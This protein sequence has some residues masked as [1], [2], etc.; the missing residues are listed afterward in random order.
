MAAVECE[1]SGL[2]Q[3]VDTARDAGLVSDC[4]IMG[5][6]GDKLWR[7]LHFAGNVAGCGEE[8]A[9]VLEAET[10]TAGPGG[11]YEALHQMGG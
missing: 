6:L 9:V 2:D 1:D 5:V 11:V 7:T 10:L 8:L 3:G 4:K